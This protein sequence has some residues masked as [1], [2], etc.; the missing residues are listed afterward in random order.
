MFSLFWQF[1]TAIYYI[2]PNIYGKSEVTAL[3]KFLSQKQVN[4]GLDLQGGSHL[5]L[6]S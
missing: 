4:L 5:L 3:P 1:V 6:E 2:I